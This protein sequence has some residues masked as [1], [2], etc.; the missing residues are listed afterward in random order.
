MSRLAGRVALVTGVASG[1]GAAC[2]TRF[3]AEGATVVGLDVS[4]DADHH[5][6]VRDEAAVSAAVTA[7][8]GAHGRID[9]LVNAAGVAGVGPVHALAE[10][11]WDRVVDINLKGTFLVSKHVLAPMMEQRSGSVIHLASIEGIQ[12]MELATAYNASKGGVVNLT[13]QMAIDYGRLG[14]RVNCICPGFID[15]P[16]TSAFSGPGMEAIGERI[17]EA[18]MLGR[19]GRPEEVAAVA[20]FLASDDASFVSGHPLVVDGGFT[21]GHRFGLAALFGL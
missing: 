11:E 7:V 10:E 15:T 14:I 19:F 21:A 20:A 17:T 8:V 16:M 3:G 6:D 2:A 18:H 13:R 12:A 9:I 4:G 1:I 5:V